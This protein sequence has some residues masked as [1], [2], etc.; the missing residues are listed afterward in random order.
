M[1]FTKDR[2]DLWLHGAECFI[3]TKLTPSF[4]DFRYFL[5]DDN[6]RLLQYRFIIEVRIYFIVCQN[7][8]LVIVIKC[9]KG[10]PGCHFILFLQ[11]LCKCRAILCEHGSFSSIIHVS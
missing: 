10:I 7:G 6:S 2:F 1:T 8:K 4:S 11:E 5:A 3:S 9:Q